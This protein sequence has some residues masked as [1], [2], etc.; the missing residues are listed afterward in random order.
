VKALI[1]W[2]EKREVFGVGVGRRVRGNQ[3][4]IQEEANQE[5]SVQVLGHSIYR[6]LVLRGIENRL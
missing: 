6:P 2:C 1:D 3:K 5:A 4:N